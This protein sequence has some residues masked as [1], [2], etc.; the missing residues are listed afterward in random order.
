MKIA[1]IAH[2]LRAGGG[3]SIGRNV[4]RELSKAMPSASLTATIPLIREY[5]ALN[6][7]CSNVKLEHIDTCNAAKRLW[8]DA[9]LI[10]KL[11][12][13]MKPTVILALGNVPTSYCGCPQV[14]LVQDAHLFY[15]DEEF[16]HGSIKK[17]L[18]KK[19]QRSAI[20]SSLIS[21]DTVLC[22]TQVAAER[23]RNYYS[24]HGRL[25][26]IPNALSGSLKAPS[27]PV[28][29]P[30]IFTRAGP[31]LKRLL[32]VARYYP[33][34]NIETL[35]KMFEQ[36]SRQL[37][38]VVLFVTLEEAHHPNVRAVLQKIQE[39]NLRNR[40][41]NIGAVD[42]EDLAGFYLHAD[43]LV[44]PTLLESFSATYL[45]AMAFSCP[46]ITSDRDFAKEI[47]GDAAIYV[48]PLST[49]SIYR[50]VNRI[51][52]DTTLAKAM[53]ENGQKRLRSMSVSWRD[54]AVKL[55]WVLEMAASRAEKRGESKVS[56][57]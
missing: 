9:Y 11:L 36:Y 40:I 37:E 14:V 24:F 25:D 43:A 27:R 3:I 41:V 46:I 42:Q 1:I 17:R 44:M 2:A 20:R 34:K 23:F 45:E 16:P 10:P 38:G 8:A 12:R 15:S 56:G 30:E 6:A 31:K 54:V 51:L 26:V 13:S 7:E 22:Q 55:A 48:D 28:P 21:L 29:I 32:Y 53:A 47:C 49:E 4:I 57:K 52:S 5:E 33:H 18:I 50:A 39:P 19:L 35:V